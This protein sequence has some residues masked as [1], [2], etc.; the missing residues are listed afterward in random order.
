MTTFDK[1]DTKEI[2][3]AGASIIL[4]ASEFSKYDLQD[5]VKNIDSKARI[6]LINIKSFS[7]HDLKDI[8][9]KAKAPGVVILRLP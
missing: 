6:E 9:S 8:I 3:K 7:K 1:H 5:I 2:A 4:D